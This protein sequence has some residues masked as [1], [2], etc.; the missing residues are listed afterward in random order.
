MA[1]LLAGST[2]GS[3]PEANAQLMAGIVAKSARIVERDYH[4]RFVV[5]FWDDESGYSS[6]ILK[7]LEEE[8]ISVINVSEIIPTP[9]IDAYKIPGDGHPTSRANML[10]A[11]GLM[12]R[13]GY[14][15]DKRL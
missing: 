13:L 4:A 12:E 2:P 10:I 1:N 8:N 11:R 6:L 5:L 9:Q 7:G 14:G 15:L 3:S